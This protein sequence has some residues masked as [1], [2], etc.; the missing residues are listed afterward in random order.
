MTSPAASQAL[1]ILGQLLHGLGAGVQAFSAGTALTQTETQRGCGPLGL[2]Q[3][4]AGALERAAPGQQDEV[5]R[6]GSLPAGTGSSR[7]RGASSPAV[8][9]AAAAASSCDLLPSLLS[10]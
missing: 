1:E 5:L 9:T 8:G 6:A 3:G 10:S 4:I 7:G 2:L